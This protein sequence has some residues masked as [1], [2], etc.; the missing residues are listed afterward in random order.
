MAAAADSV[1]RFVRARRPVIRGPLPGPR[2]AALLERD[3]AV[4]SPSM[5][6]PYPLAVARGEGLWVTDV[7]GNEFLD[8]TAGI[9][10]TATGH[11]HPRVVQAVVRQSERFLHMSGTDFVYEA[12]VELGERLS[13][14]A[15]IDGPARVF[16]GNSGAEAN[17]GAMKLARWYTHRPYFLAFNGSFHGRTFGALSLTASRAIQHAG[18]GALLPG[19]YHVPYPS[20]SPGGM[21]TEQV[22]EQIDELF[23]RLAPPEEFAAVFVEPIQGEGGYIVPP[24]DFLPRLRKLTTHHGILLVADE[25]QSG[26]GRTGR[27]FAVEHWDV[28]PDIVTVAKGIASG[29]PLSAFIARAEIMGWPDGAHGTTFGGNP[30][31]CAAALA[32]LDLLEGGLVENAASIG[33]ELL[34]SLRALQA[35]H[36]DLVRDVRGKGLMIGIELRTP[37]LASQLVLAAYQ[38]GLLA[39][40]AGFNAVRL[41]PALTVTPGEA[42]V[43]VEVLE[44]ALTAIR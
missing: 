16:F 1:R 21:T 13:G 7:D 23:L 38:R 9:A 32:T 41:S 29:L 3:A 2:A 42:A 28:A 14:L 22:F 5:T 26:M 6:R 39:L 17:E 40:P 19:V 36:A 15:P 31:A 30:V 18:F 20:A 11:A 34:V 10:V 44:Q 24:D 12:E 43:A 4:M 33:A 27:M 25:V 8:F 37:D 35:R